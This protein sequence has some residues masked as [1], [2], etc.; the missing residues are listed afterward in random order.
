MSVSNWSQIK[1]SEPNL[2]ES[3]SDKAIGATDLSL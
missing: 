1:V 2:S 3:R